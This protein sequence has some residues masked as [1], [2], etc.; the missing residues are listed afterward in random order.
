MLTAMGMDNRNVKFHL[1]NT[2]TFQT[3]CQNTTRGQKSPQGLQNL[4]DDSVD[5]E[6]PCVKAKREEGP[7]CPG[8]SRPAS[9]CGPDGAQTLGGRWV[10]HRGCPPRIFQV[11]EV[12]G[13]ESLSEKK[14][15]KCPDCSTYRFTCCKHFLWL[16]LA[17]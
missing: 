17:V 10:G 3:A 16:K 15:R 12:S 5:F 1:R 11:R 13:T 2:H 14:K 4:E 7:G 8:A 9:C 6:L